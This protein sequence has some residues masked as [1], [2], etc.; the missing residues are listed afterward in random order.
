MMGNTS[1]PT[2]GPLVQER[3]DEPSDFSVLSIN[4]SSSPGKDKDREV[5]AKQEG[6]F[7]L[8]FRML[9]VLVLVVSAIAVSIGVYLYT[10]NQETEAFEVKFDSD[11]SKILES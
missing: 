9:V 2:S 5:I 4:P 7:V 3:H 1:S 6:R 10:S 8:A 11:A